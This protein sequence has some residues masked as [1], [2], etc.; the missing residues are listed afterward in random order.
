MPRHF[1]SRDN[2]NILDLRPLPPV[3][4]VT[5]AVP[6][7]E[8]PKEA[9]IPET[10]PLRKET[11]IVE[12]STQRSESRKDLAL[13]YRLVEYERSQRESLLELSRIHG[14]LNERFKQME[15]NNYGLKDQIF[16][17]K[18]L[19]G[20]VQHHLSFLDQRGIEDKGE[21]R[22]LHD[23]S[24]YSS[25][26]LN[27]VNSRLSENVKGLEG[28]KATISDLKKEFT[29]SKLEFSKEIQGL[30]DKISRLESEKSILLSFLKELDD[31]LTGS[32]KTGDSNLL[33]IAQVLLNVSKH[34]GDNDQQ[35]LLNL[36][37]EM[38]S[39][40]INL[41]QELLEESKSQ[42]QL[43]ENLQELHSKYL[44]DSVKLE[45]L[46]NLVSSQISCILKDKAVETSEIIKTVSSL[47]SAFTCKK[48]GDVE[49]FSKI[50][51][52][53][54][55]LQSY[56]EDEISSLKQELVKEQAANTKKSQ[57]ERRWNYTL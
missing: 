5:V 55:N 44:K 49:N 47:K 38:Q 27:S 14:K 43:K 32:V 57:S 33:K 25:Q 9:E 41:K 34:Q 52:S 46:E 37:S 30:K 39:S 31:R 23:K 4:S 16:Y 56:F 15:F 13:E 42:L 51:K 8:I 20:S 24:S 7:S 21:L 29:D 54:H 28:I 10:E 45:N 3:A 12:V 6:K 2:G 40:L 53:L 11:D 18:E 50:M 1:E 19:L 26:E 22:R 17:F 35:E 36:K 48:K